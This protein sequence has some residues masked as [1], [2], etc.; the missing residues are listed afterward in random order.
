LFGIRSSKPGVIPLRLPVEYPKGSYSPGVGN[1]PYPSDNY[2]P[3]AFCGAERY[4]LLARS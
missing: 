3:Y 1:L 2:A 4:L